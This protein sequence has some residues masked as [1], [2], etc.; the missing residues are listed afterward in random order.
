MDFPAKNSQEY[1]FYIE[2][3]RPVFYIPE[4]MTGPLV[5][6]LLGIGWSPPAVYLGPAG[7]TGLKV[8]SDHI[9]IHAFLKLLI[10]EAPVGPGSYHTHVTQ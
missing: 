6:L 5:F 7:N 1:N 9:L 8:M 10:Q 4:I 3:Q 2:P